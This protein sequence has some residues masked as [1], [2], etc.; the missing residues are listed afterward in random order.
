[1]DIVLQNYDVDDDDGGARGGDAMG[2]ANADDM[3]KASTHRGPIRGEKWYLL[4]PNF[5]FF[6]VLRANGIRHLFYSR[7]L[8]EH[9]A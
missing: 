7:F 1:M 9:N 5:Q 6:Y 8:S 3:T 2:I 4:P